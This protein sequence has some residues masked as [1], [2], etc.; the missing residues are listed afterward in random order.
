MSAVYFDTL[1]ELSLEIPP[2]GLGKNVTVEVPVYLLGLV[3]GP[4]KSGLLL[5]TDFLSGKP[6]VSKQNAISFDMLRSG[7]PL[8]D[9][10]I[11]SIPCTRT[12]YSSLLKRFKSDQ[13]LFSKAQFSA[14]SFDLTYSPEG[15]CIGKEMASANNVADVATFKNLAAAK[16]L[17]E[18]F[19]KLVNDDIQSRVAARVK[20]LLKNN[21]AKRRRVDEGIFSSWRQSRV[22][23]GAD[24]AFHQNP[25]DVETQQFD[26]FVAPRISDETMMSQPERQVPNTSLLTD[27]TVNT[28]GKSVG[29]ELV[30]TS[31]SSNSNGTLISQNQPTRPVAVIA[32]SSLRFSSQGSPSSCSLLS[33]KFDNFLVNRISINS[34]FKLP[35]SASETN[36]GHV[37]EIKGFFRSPLPLDH[38][39]VKPYG[40][41]LKFSG[42]RL[43][44][45][46]DLGSSNLDYL[47]LEFPSVEET[48]RFLGL[49]EEEDWFLK[50][51][52]V[53]R[54]LQRILDRSGPIAAS[55]TRRSTKLAGGNTERSYWTCCGTLQSLSQGF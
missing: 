42:F 52:S 46:E 34:L 49:L 21:D 31:N 24:L 53:I 10:F 55:V 33:D 26:D 2:D 12:C 37:F 4:K 15:K 51:A 5:V 29:T 32:E 28:N 43:F 23:H 1:N 6:F 48:C 30:C 22:T 36:K 3:D 27:T 14:V 7:G 50:H 18:R 19:T 9:D 35:E 44:L 40:R 45:F 11:F 54:D 38:F 20:A 39:V 47:E 25:V 16:A 17:F 8:P 13:I 41:T